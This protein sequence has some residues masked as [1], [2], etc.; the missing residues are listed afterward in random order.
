MR[1][2]AVDGTTVD[3]P[4]TGANRSRYR[5]R[6]GGL[7]PKM[8]L[9]ALFDL[10]SG[11]VVDWA[12]GADSYGEQTL[13]RRITRR[14]L[15]RDTLILGDAYYCQFANFAMAVAAGGHASFIARSFIPKGRGRGARDFIHTIHRPKRRGK[16]WKHGAWLRLPEAVAVRVITVRWERPGFRTKQVRI[17][18]TLIEKEEF[19]MEE[20]ASLHFR[21]WEAELRFRELKTT[22][23][24]DSL[25]CKSP[26]MLDKELTMHMLALNLVRAMAAEA[27]EAAAKAGAAPA[28]ISFSSA[29]NQTSEWLR[30]AFVNAIP[31]KQRRKIRA[32]FRAALADCV[33]RKR[34]DRSEPRAVRK[35]PKTH[36]PL[37]VKRRE[38][39]Q[40]FN[41]KAA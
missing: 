5:P 31:A 22:M 39:P 11:G 34:P 16:G 14:S 26:A 29:M 24:M 41:P 10:F 19:P 8:R 21:R 23:D 18:T 15:G 28:D 30:L 40:Y 4:D 1:V 2:M 17:A 38:H 35:R 7:L 36:P 20:I 33:V 37:K 3:V 27:A 13:W 9:V 6:G 12:R 32:M 25:R